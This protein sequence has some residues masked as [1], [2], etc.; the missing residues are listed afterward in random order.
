MG[1]V[2]EDIWKMSRNRLDHEGNSDVVNYEKLC[3]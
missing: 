3:W 2:L 1:R